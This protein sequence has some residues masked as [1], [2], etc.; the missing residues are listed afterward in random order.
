M[1]ANAAVQTHRPLLANATGQKHRLFL[2]EPVRQQAGSYS[3]FRPC[4]SGVRMRFREWGLTNPDIL[5][6]AKA[7]QGPCRYDLFANAVARLCSNGK[8]GNRVAW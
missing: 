5:R 2:A 8:T 1:L 6:Q 4:G 7:L 3:G